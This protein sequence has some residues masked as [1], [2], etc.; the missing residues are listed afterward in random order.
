[1]LRGAKAS[2]TASAWKFGTMTDDWS[3]YQSGPF[4]PHWCEV[5]ACCEELCMCG[6]TCAQHSSDS[7]SP[8]SVEGCGCERL[9]EPLELPV[10]PQDR[11]NGNGN[12]ER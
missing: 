1:M 10:P 6:H 9:V 8:C 12:G 2:L 7:E 4:C 11:G 5:S 3:D